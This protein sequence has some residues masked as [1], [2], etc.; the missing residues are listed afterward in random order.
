MR[1]IL[2]LLLLATVPASGEETG[3]GRLLLT[4][5]Q[6][7]ALDQQRFATPSDSGERRL[8]VNGEI[9]RSSGGTIRWINGRSDWDGGAPPPALPVG[10]SF[11]PR[12]GAR[13][14]LLDNGEIVVPRR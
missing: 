10:D 2:P 1:I 14:P 13:Q 12:T 5:Q 7:Q 4:P 8:T 9:R 6:R 11:N 3:L